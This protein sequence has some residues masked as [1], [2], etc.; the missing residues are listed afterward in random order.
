MKDTTYLSRVIEIIT[1]L[2]KDSEKGL[3]N[4][5]QET[6]NFKQFIW[7]DCQH[8]ATSEDFSQQQEYND[9]V[10]ESNL[11]VKKTN[12]KFVQTN[13]L[14]KSLNTPFFG[15]VDFK[16]DE[17]LEN[18]YIGIHGI[19]EDLINYVYDWRTPI[20]SLYYNFTIGASFYETLE[21]KIQGEITLKRQ[22]K[23]S[24]SKL[25]RVIENNINIDDEILQEVLSSNSSAKMTNIVNTIQK[26]QNMVIRNEED[27][28]LIVEGIAGSGKTSV[29]MHRIAYLLYR[30][31]ELNND[32]ILIFSP[33]DIFTEYIADVLPELGENNVLST[34]FNDFTRRYLGSYGIL[35]TYESYLNKCFQGENE[36]TKFKFSNDYQNSLKTY[37]DNYLKDLFFRTGIILN[38]KKF[39]KEE[40]TDLLQNKYLKLSLAERLDKITEYLC[41]KIKASFKKRGQVIKEKLISILNKNIDVKFIYNSYLKTFNEELTDT[42]NYEDLPGLLYLNFEL[43]DYPYEDT[44]KHIVIDEAQDYSALQFYLIKKMFPK[45]MFTILGDTNQMINPY[46][47]YESLREIDNFF[48]NKGKYLELTKTYRSTKEITDFANSIL[49]INNIEAVRNTGEKVEL[50]EEN[51]LVNQLIVDINKLK[52]SNQKR[53]AIITKDTK[54]TEKIFDLLNGKIDISCPIKMPNLKDIVVMPTY[55]AKG[56]EF[57]A[58]IVYTN[59]N[60]KFTKE[61]NKLYYVACTRALHQLIIYNQ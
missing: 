10:E 38:N 25:E 23:I 47:H 32:N 6:E 42:I 37:L 8:L 11:Q 21:G 48:D 58:V 15:R 55:M 28:I 22:Y 31:K 51:D 36:K 7:K 56:L 61:E 1:K 13:K 49:N 16:S 4:Q 12:E 27:K 9:L 19:E 53:I 46:C 57:D 52:K 29:A 5:K 43:T 14:R 54:E 18:V 41:L 35:E 20:A 2:L 34:T 30:Y 24:N 45:A 33:N 59:K 26:E 40:L 3:E 39:S 60:N 44:V 17:G 50:K